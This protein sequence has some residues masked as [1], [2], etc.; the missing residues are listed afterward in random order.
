M[1]K[2]NYIR[3]YINRPTYFR[4]NHCNMTKK[5]MVKVRAKGQVKSYCRE[6]FDSL[7]LIAMNYF[8]PNP[9]HHF[10]SGREPHAFINMSPHHI[11]G[12]CVTLLNRGRKIPAIKDLRLL[13]QCGLKEAKDQV[14]WWESGEIG[15]VNTDMSKY[16]IDMKRNRPYEYRL[17]W[18]QIQTGNY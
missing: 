1:G 9:N 5:H 11:R 8:E 17:A 2:S 16:Y 7:A 4:C 14:D 10:L 12:H 15:W 6:C 18:K 13:L 3:P